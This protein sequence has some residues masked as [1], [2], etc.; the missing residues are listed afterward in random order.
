[1]AA[2]FSLSVVTP[3]KVFFDGE[4]SQIIVRTTVGDIG[5]LAN[6]TSLVADLPSGPLKVKQEDGSWRIAAISTGLLKVGGNKVSILANAVE[7][8]DEIDLNW[9]KRSEEDARRRLKEQE[10]KHQLD[11]AELKLKRALNRISV[12]SGNK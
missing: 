7:W 5:I 2:S 4:T 9:A 10:D 3:E 6:H 12:G 11:L 8:A 1:M